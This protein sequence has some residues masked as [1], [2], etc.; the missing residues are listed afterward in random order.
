MSC[1]TLDPTTLQ[2]IACSRVLVPSA[3]VRGTYLITC[4]V[5]AG[6]EPGRRIAGARPIPEPFLLTYTRV[7]ARHLGS[8]SL[9]HI[10]LGCSLCGKPRWLR[11]CLWWVPSTCSHVLTEY[12][13]THGWMPSSRSHRGL[14]VK[15]QHGRCSV[16]A[17]S[18]FG[19]AV[20]EHLGRVSP[21]LEGWAMLSP[22]IV[23]CVSGIRD[24]S[25]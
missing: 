24:I 4:Q 1:V 16:W 17:T 20:C 2:R 6:R 22:S 11:C 13:L 19:R 23:L 25:P 15:P 9:L 8:R 21:T 3:G 12:S 10:L 7:I 5:R 18:I 14:C